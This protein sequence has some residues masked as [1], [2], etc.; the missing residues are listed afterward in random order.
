MFNF[1]KASSRETFDANEA[2]IAQKKQEMTAAV[3][4]GDFDKVATLAQEAKAMETAKGEM[5]GNAQDEALE[6]NKKI[7]EAAEAARE[8]A[9]QEAA[10]AER[11]RLDAENS[12]KEAAEIL[13][14][15]Q[16]K[17]SEPAA[18]PSPEA[19]PKPESD[20][21]NPEDAKRRNLL[22]KKIEEYGER[23][24]KN[25]DTSSKMY[26][27]A[28]YKIAVAEFLL[29][30]SDGKL[31]GGNILPLKDALR[32]EYGSE[33][34]EREFVNAVRVIRDYAETGGQHVRGGTG[35]EGSSPK[36]QEAAP[37]ER[38]RQKGLL[39]PVMSAE[40]IETPEN[41]SRHVND[42]WYERMRDLPARERTN[43]I[44]E[45]TRSFI[46]ENS[47]DS[48]YFPMMEKY[49]RE[50]VKKR[51]IPVN[52]FFLDG[53]MDI[54]RYE[55]KEGNTIGYDI[56]NVAYTSSPE[57]VDGKLTGNRLVRERIRGSRD[58]FGKPYIREAFDYENPNLLKELYDAVV[59]AKEKARAEI[60]SVKNDDS[61]SS[62][63]VAPTPSEEA[64]GQNEKYRERNIGAI[65]GGIHKIPSGRWIIDSVQ[66]GILQIG[67]GAK[68]TITGDTRGCVIKRSRDS[69]LTILGKQTGTLIKVEG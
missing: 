64:A 25:P 5:L 51:G 19:S 54:D 17:S 40:K 52:P 4:A 16:G 21:F 11:A 37:P 58:E 45:E 48:E 31:F 61:P 38:P 18:E 3:A 15:L 23:L 55:D 28:S 33:F 9:A 47:F 34:N 49:L 56:Y 8:R 60:A 68:V 20:I 2:G 69:E 26:R 39:P 66:G 36:N 29:N 7:D 62:E 10:R 24:S 67:A 1:E 46:S 22:R 12:Q 6:I 30:K 59:V 32:H 41:D 44:R 43:L 65:H 13:A 50:E 35:P 27:D 63:K 42:A 53:L 57:L 14:R